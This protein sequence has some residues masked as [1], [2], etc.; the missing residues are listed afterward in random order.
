MWLGYCHEHSCPPGGG[1]VLHPEMQYHWVERSGEP[2]WVSTHPGTQPRPSVLAVAAEAGW[3][4]AM[5]TSLG[6]SG[7][8]DVGSFACS[9][10]GCVGP[11]PSW[12]SGGTFSAVTK[13]YLS[14]VFRPASGPQFPGSPSDKGFPDYLLVASPPPT[15]S[16][17]TGLGCFS[18]NALKR[19]SRACRGVGFSGS[20]N[21]EGLATVERW[22]SSW[23]RVCPGLERWLSG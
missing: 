14:G 23:L 1:G 16:G 10:V 6:D 17:S 3:G 22:L 7:W 11:R 2:L 20:F 21:T 12:K 18:C 8:L 15:W 13:T 4:E 19:R 9:W 5:L